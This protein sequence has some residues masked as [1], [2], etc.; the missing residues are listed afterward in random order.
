MNE[1]SGRKRSADQRME[2]LI[3]NL[4]QTGVLLAAGIVLV[5][6]GIYLARHG[7]ELPDFRVFH[8]QPIELRTVPGIIHA[9][10]ELGGRGLIQLGFLVLIATPVLRVFVS[11]IA[12]A[13]Q[14]DWLYVAVVSIVLAVLL[15]SLFSGG[16]AL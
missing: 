7:R 2:V 14:R 10:T 11:G 15:Y 6:G 8:G 3:G 12:F 13:R 5:G 4:L 16:L 9:A 1:D